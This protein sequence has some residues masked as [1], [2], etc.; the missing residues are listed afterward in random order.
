[1]NVREERK[2]WET[3]GVSY[4][5]YKE[6]WQSNYK[7]ALKRHIKNFNSVEVQYLLD[8]F[9]LHDSPEFVNLIDDTDKGLAIFCAFEFCKGKNKFIKEYCFKFDGTFETIELENHNLAILK[10]YKTHPESLKNILIYYYWRRTKTAKVFSSDVKI[11]KNHIDKLRIKINSI[12]SHLSKHNLKKYRF[13][14]FG[15]LD[16]EPIFIFQIDRQT[17]IDLLI[18]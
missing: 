3:L 13:I 5:K 18:H 4:R 17:G 2:Y 12:A 1:M 10:L 6:Q 11:E 16:N 14:P 7:Y 9:E 8:L 15:I